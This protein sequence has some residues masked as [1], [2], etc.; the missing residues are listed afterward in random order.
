[1]LV[2]SHHFARSVGMAQIRLHTL[3]SL[4]FQQVHAKKQLLFSAL[5]SKKRQ[6]HFS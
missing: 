1:M 2:H 5:L 6:F 4:L 3:H